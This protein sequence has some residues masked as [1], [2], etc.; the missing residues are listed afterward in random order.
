[1]A[2][3]RIVR[4]HKMLKKQLERAML[5]KERK[6]KNESISG[7]AEKKIYL[8]IGNLLKSIYNT[9]IRKKQIGKNE[10]KRS[11]REVLEIFIYIASYGM[12]GCA[13]ILLLI[14][15]LPFNTAIS[16]L[17]RSNL[18]IEFLIYIFGSGCGFYILYDFSKGKDE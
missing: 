3:P 5:K 17:A 2:E 6:E 16:N 15:L 4:E 7:V 8:N 1:M 14:T 11:F 13:L 12:I 18:L 10:I 9:V